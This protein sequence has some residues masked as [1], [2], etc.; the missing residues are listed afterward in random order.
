M[1]A[2]VFGTALLVATTLAGC[3]TRSDPQ[4]VAWVKG[5]A[6]DV[7]PSGAVA[8][9]P[10]LFVPQIAFDDGCPATLEIFRAQLQDPEHPPQYL[11]EPV[12]RV[13]S[14]WGSKERA[15]AALRSEIDALRKAAS[16]A[17]ARRSIGD[18][19]LRDQVDEAMATLFDRHLT[20]QAMLAAVMCTPDEEPAKTGA[21][22]SRNGRSGRSSR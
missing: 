7:P 15:A 11:T 9:P 3:A 20:A 6:P 8:A 13:I 18:L 16:D 4:A 17:L 10:H 19:A 2:Q 1:K 21:Q 5:K 22:K 14:T 12:A